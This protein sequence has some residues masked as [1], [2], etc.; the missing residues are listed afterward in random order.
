MA[1][2]DKELLNIYNI[3][4]D[5]K[6]EKISGGIVPVHVIHCDFNINYESMLST[7]VKVKWK[8]CVRFA[9][10]NMDIK[11]LTNPALAN[12]LITIYKEDSTSVM[13]TLQ[14]EGRI[15]FAHYG[16]SFNFLPTWLFIYSIIGNI[17]K[18]KGYLPSGDLS[19]YLYNMKL[20]DETKEKWKDMKI[21]QVEIPQF[22]MGEDSK[23]KEISELSIDDFEICNY[24]YD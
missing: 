19:V 17:L 11:S 21:Q 4:K 5:K 20:D 24:V 10:K 8:A 3:L 22:T 15:V 12:K 2:V 18:N 13:A 14:E 6:P 7:L 16:A 1:H 23:D 9:L